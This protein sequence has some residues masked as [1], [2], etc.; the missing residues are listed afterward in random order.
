M[1]LA[2]Y[3]FHR[4]CHGHDLFFLFR[5]CS[6]LEDLLPCDNAGKPDCFT[7]INHKIQLGGDEP[8]G[9]EL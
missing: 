6:F 5:D 2:L 1:F 3:Q 4:H 8:G 7:L 9:T